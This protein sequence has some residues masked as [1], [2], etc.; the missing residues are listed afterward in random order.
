MWAITSYYNPHKFKSRRKNFTLFRHHLKC[1]LIAV[2]FNPDS[3]FELKSGIDCDILI[4]VKDGSI[5]WQK[6]RLLNVA[7]SYLPSDEKNVAWIDSDI[8]F[9]SNSWI[10]DA[11]RLLESNNTIQLFS[12]LIDGKR[13]EEYPTQSDS[14]YSGSGLVWKIR[15]GVSLADALYPSSTNEM[16]TT[17]FGLAWAAN[18]SFL[19]S[20]GLY[21]MMIIGS[22]DRAYACAIYNEFDA[23]CKTLELNDDRKRHYIAWAKKAHSNCQGKISNIQG[24][25]FHLWHGSIENRRYRE[26]HLHFSKFSFDPNINIGYGADGPLK[27]INCRDNI[28][29]FVKQY[30]RER[31]DDN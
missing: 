14:Q 24:A 10:N 29:L 4:Q 15:N 30:L 28:E 11:E 27:L 20:I 9:L 19:K 8:I 5:L 26:R 25:I 3:N 22:G 2:E 23:A 12:H 1:P 17:C 21:E 31:Q 16:R 7:I 6:E 18:V 13:N